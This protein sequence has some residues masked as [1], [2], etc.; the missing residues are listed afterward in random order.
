MLLDSSYNRNY[1]N[2]LAFLS[3]GSAWDKYPY[4][5]KKSRNADNGV[6]MARKQAEVP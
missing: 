3:G 6:V 1:K 4:L 2:T 5:V